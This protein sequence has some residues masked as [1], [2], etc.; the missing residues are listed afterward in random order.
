MAQELCKSRVKRL[1]I[2]GQLRLI[3]RITIALLNEDLRIAVM[4]YYVGTRRDAI[5]LY[6]NI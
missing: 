3:W 4:C 5:D 1:L 2:R 6:V